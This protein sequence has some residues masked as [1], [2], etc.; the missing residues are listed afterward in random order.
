MRLKK[1]LQKFILTVTS[2]CLCSSIALA[3]PLP[4]LGDPSRTKLSLQKEAKMGKQ[5]IL[6]LKASGYVIQD[7]ID[8]SYI[9]SIGFKLVA[10]HPHPGRKFHFYIIDDDNINAF[11]GPGGYICVNS[12]LILNSKNESELA[13][14]LAHEIGHVVQGH[15]ARQIENMSTV[16]LSTIAGLLAAVALGTQSGE[17]AT[18]AVAA[19]VAGAQQSMINFTRSNEK[20]ADSVGMT[21]MHNS[22]FDPEALPAFFKRLQQEERY[23]ASMPEILS[24]HPLTEARIAEAEN[25]AAQFKVQYHKKPIRNSETFYLVRAR[26]RVQT[27]KDPHAVLAYFKKNLQAKNYQNKLAEEYGYGY[28]L[29]AADLPKQAYKVLYHLAEQHPDN[30]IIHIT[31]AHNLTELHQYKKAL[32]VLEPLYDAYPDNYAITLYYADTL[33]QA[34][35]A[36]HAMDIL[37]QHRLHFPK[38]PIPYGLLSQAQGKAGFEAQAYQTRAN[39]YLDIDQPRQ[40]LNQLEMAEKLPDNDKYMQARVKAQIKEVK[41]LMADKKGKKK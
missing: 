36:Q 35:Q 28:A 15:I 38:D 30:I 12:G 40:A 24:D 7:P 39:F 27:A 13:G 31:L 4:N 34:N 20:E 3:D 17:A 10:A 21:I 1:T 2:F 29:L 41:A 37:L 9:K 14:V 19:T 18:G 16:R 6:A 8:E 5:F 23:Y 33:L 11:A 22:G 25:R 26:L 32:T